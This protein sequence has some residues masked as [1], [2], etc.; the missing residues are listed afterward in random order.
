MFLARAGLTEFPSTAGVMAGTG[1]LSD[2]EGI[3]FMSLEL[4]G[5][6]H[7]PLMPERFSMFIVD[8]DSGGFID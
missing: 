7:R 8:L 4:G 5:Y 3:W 1:D 2:V 6:L